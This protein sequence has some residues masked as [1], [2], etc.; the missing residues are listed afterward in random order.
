MGWYTD[1]V[2]IHMDPTVVDY[3]GTKIALIPWINPENEQEITEFISNCEASI[4]GA[5]L[6]LKGYEVMKGMVCPHGMESKLFDRFEMVLTGHFHTKSSKGNI[7]YLGSQMEFF[8]NDAGDPKYFHIF[9][10]DKR[11]ITPVVNPI[12]IFE[13]IYYDDSEKNYETINLDYL[14]NK[15]VKVIVVNKTDQ[16]MFERFIDRIQNRK[17]LELKIQENFSEFIGEN[18]NDDT[19]SLE[20]TDS[21][22]RSY[23]DAVETDLDR[24]RIKSEVNTLMVE[25]QTLTIA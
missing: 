5:H 1:C 15:F 20:D 21:L 8:W 24:N 9:N 22:L 10:T 13:K 17:I 3:D 2:K 12:T 7:H 25:A 4:I 6:E 23:I 11:E 16:F 18:V 14:N 19:I